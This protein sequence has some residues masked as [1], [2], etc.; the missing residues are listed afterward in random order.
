MPQELAGIRKTLEIVRRDQWRRIRLQ[1]NA[2]WLRERLDSLG[3]NVSASES[4]IIAL[5][6]G[7]EERMAQAALALQRFGVFG[8]PFFSP[9][10]AK[11]RACVRLSVHAGLTQTELQ[12]IGDAAG[13]V[14]QELSV[15]DWAST[16]RRKVRSSPGCTGARQRTWT[17][18]G[19]PGTA[20][21][22]EA[23]CRALMG[24]GCVAAAARP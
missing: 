20:V 8:A 9:A 18:D 6:A 13:A 15:Q 21:S 12:R 3:Y 14:R 5:E 16:K 22:P 4:Q 17:P 19:A 11:N 10:T 24:V 2:A 1:A 23:N 7:S